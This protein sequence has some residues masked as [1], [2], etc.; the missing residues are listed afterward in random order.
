MK[1]NSACYLVT[2]GS[3]I[4]GLLGL[5]FAI[6]S[7][8][9]AAANGTPDVPKAVLLGSGIVGSLIGATLVFPAVAAVMARSRAP[10]P[11]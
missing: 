10:K 5:L 9:A 2:V 11:G 7:I 6:A 3:V 1:R 4:I 8:R